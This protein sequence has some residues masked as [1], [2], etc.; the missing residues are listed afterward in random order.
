MLLLRS[1][2]YLTVTC[3][4]CDADLPASFVKVTDNEVEPAA[5]PFHVNPEPLPLT[6]TIPLLDEV[7]SHVTS[8]PPD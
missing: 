5:T 3:T 1:R 2:F 4:D 6:P 8:E 7:T